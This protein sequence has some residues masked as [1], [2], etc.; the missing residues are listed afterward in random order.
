MSVGKCQNLEASY[1]TYTGFVVVME[2]GLFFLK[3]GHD[4]IWSIEFLD[5]FLIFRQR[6]PQ[7]LS[8]IEKA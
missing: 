6:L 8:K 3:L 2:H 1:T 7:N 5:S 4:G